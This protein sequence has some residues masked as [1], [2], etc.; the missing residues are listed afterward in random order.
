MSLLKYQNLSLS[1]NDQEILHH[2]DLIIPKNQITVIVGQSG[3]GKSTLLKATMGLLSDDA[4]ITDGKILFEE[5]DL[6]KKDL[7]QYRG[8]KIG[9]IF[10]NPLTYFDDY[11]NIEQ[12]FYESLYTH[13]KYSKKQ[14]RKIAIHYL[15]QMGLEETILNKY[16]FELSGGMAQ[17]VMIALVLCL[18][19]SLVLADEPT[20]SLDVVIQKQILDYLLKLKKHTTF[21]FVTHNIQVARYIADQ[22]VVIKE[23]MIVEKG[24]VETIFN[25][26]KHPYTKSLLRKE[27][28]NATI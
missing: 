23:G 1:Y 3:S 5:N 19:P 7:N 6:L 4:K 9:M 28:N 24:N 18:Q 14:S 13:F 11:Q 2:I 25:A 27:K 8:R 16:P 21:V 12:H 10:Q 22:I 15:K 26:S 20:S 17:R